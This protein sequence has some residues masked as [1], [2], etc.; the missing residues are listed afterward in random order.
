MPGTPE[1]SAIKEVWTYEDMVVG[2]I[3]TGSEGGW[4]AANTASFKE[5][6]EESGITLRWSDPQGEVEY[7]NESFAISSP[8]RR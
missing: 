2:F 8:M 6:A 7:Q 5:T 3:Q 4:R 1:P